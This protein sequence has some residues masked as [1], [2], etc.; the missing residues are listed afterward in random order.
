MTIMSSVIPI[1][2]PNSIGRWKMIVKS[3]TAGLDAGGRM[4]GLMLAD[5]TG[6]IRDSRVR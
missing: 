2:I 4:D 1:E 3:C 5:G 6:P